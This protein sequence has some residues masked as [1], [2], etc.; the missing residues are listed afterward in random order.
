MISTKRQTQR[1]QLY[2]NMS[3]I[4][5]PTMRLEAMNVVASAY[6]S[7]YDRDTPLTKPATEPARKRIGDLSI[8]MPR[9]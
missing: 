8:N 2:W 6:S 7:Q 3:D 9:E 5:R 4:E 1:Y